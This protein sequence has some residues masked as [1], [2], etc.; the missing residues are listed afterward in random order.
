[1]VVGDP[2]ADLRDPLFLESYTVSLDT[3]TGSVIVWAFGK[4]HALLDHLPV[5]ES[6]KRHTF[7]RPN[8]EDAVRSHISENLNE[9]DSMLQSLSRFMRPSAVSS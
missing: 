8:D 5:V 2:P 4:A 3:A 9:L 6:E 1:M 7:T